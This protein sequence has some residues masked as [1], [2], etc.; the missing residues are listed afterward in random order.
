MDGAELFPR[1]ASLL[2]YPQPHDRPPRRSYPLRLGPLP[3]TPARR[4][5]RP[6]VDGPRRVVACAQGRPAGP[7][8]LR[9]VRRRAHLDED[10]APPAG[11]RVGRLHLGLRGDVPAAPRRGQGWPTRAQGVAPPDLRRRPLPEHAAQGRGPGGQADPPRTDARR[12]R[13]HPDAR[14]RRS[15]LRRHRFLHGRQ[16]GGHGRPRPR[17]RPQRLRR[18]AHLL[19]D[20]G[21]H[22][23]P[24]HRHHRRRQA[25]RP[26]AR[27]LRPP[28][29]LHGRR[30]HAAATHPAAPRL[31]LAGAGARSG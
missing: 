7:P 12:S 8:R 29:D 15:P 6:R 31:G 4:G 11:A 17:P 21:R 20:E 27:A 14:R 3:A 10:G 26:L 22:D 13:E 19:R 24:R 2:D 18:P 23:R 28:G 1:L 9:S 5:D 16:A 30:H 25:G